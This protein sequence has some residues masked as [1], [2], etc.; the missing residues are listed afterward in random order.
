MLVAIIPKKTVILVNYRVG[1]VSRD[2]IVPVSSPSETVRINVMDSKGTIREEHSTE[3]W[4]RG[5]IEVDRTQVILQKFVAQK[6]VDKDE[7][8]HCRSGSILFLYRAHRRH[9]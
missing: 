5:R 7:V 4:E 3:E 6:I 9:C 1:R 2:R 8:L